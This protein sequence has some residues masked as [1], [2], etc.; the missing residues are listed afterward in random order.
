MNKPVE[1]GKISVKRWMGNQLRVK[2][3]P[4][5]KIGM[6]GGWQFAAWLIRLADGGGGL[7]GVK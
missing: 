6:A 3:K 2:T 1:K 4:K 7:R 5:I